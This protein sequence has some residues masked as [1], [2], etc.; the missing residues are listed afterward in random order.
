MATTISLK[1]SLSVFPAKSRSL[2]DSLIPFPWMYFQL[3]NS[4]GDGANDAYDRAFLQL[5]GQG[6]AL[7]TNGLNAIS[8]TNTNIWSTN[9]GWFTPS[10][11]NYI[12]NTDE[13]VR[14]FF[15]LSTLS[16]GLLIC[17]RLQIGSTA[18]TLSEYV[19]S[20]S[21]VDTTTG[22]FEILVNTAEKVFVMMREK[23][24][25]GATSVCSDSSA[26]SINTEYAY[27]IYLN[28][29]DGTATLY[30]NGVEGVSA[31]NPMP[32]PYPSMNAAR[33][34]VIAG[35]SHNLTPADKLN[36]GGS[37]AIM[38]D[39]LVVRATS[40]ISSDIG[41]IAQEYADNVGDIPRT[42]VGNYL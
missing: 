23:N 19:I 7:F 31:A 38:R 39:C 29:L 30:R 2:F 12:K 5:N 17:F 14:A 26:M 22:G 42:L 40:D 35:R 18:G 15:D 8:G 3:H 1:Q 27:C 20:H 9:P 24:N 28:T 10:G 36:E 4:L 37:G 32:T 25:S 16:G 34:M 13:N 33:G 6:S 11:D 41:Q 21:G